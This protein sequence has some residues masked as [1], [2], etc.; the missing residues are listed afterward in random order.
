MGDT[1]P[2]SH[3]NST[4]YMLNQRNVQRKCLKE[5]PAIF[6]CCK[7]SCP[8]HTVSKLLKSFELN[9]AT[10]V[11]VTTILHLPFP[12]VTPRTLL[13]LVSGPRHRKQ[14]QFVQKVTAAKFGQNG[15]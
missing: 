3:K 12:V 4:L 11:C 9:P 14:L 6:T 1:K 10:L 7:P 13:A 15:L 5:A 2:S 8:L